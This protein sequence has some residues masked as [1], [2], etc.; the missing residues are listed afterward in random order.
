MPDDRQQ[1]LFGP[2]PARPRREHAAVGPAVAPPELA[3]IASRIPPTVRLGTSSWSF[4]GWA[5]IV[6][7]RD[8]SAS[9]LARDGLAAYARHPLLR[10]VGIDRTYYAPISAEVYRGY[11]LAVPETF[12][13][14]A[15]ACSDCTSPASRDGSANPK[16]LDAA[17]A[18]DAVV[19]PF[20]EGL[21][22][23]AGPLVF[24][25][26]PLGEVAGEP[27]RFAERLERFLAALPRGPMY[28]VEVRDRAV[29]GPGYA[30]ALAETGAAHCLSVHPRM[31][32]VATQ[33]AASGRPRAEG[34][35]VVRW[36][37]HVGLSYDGARV[38]YAP[39]SRLVDEDFA[40]RR[41]LAAAIRARAAAGFESFVVA[42]NKAEGS[43]PL[44]VFA[45]AAA[46]AK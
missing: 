28:A 25:F 22:A 44:T 19:A 17:W 27:E 23:K 41:A 21:G 18:G 34:P 1:F 40:T 7:D 10:T 14:L 4:P 8:A 3:E 6:Y 16:F 29:L 42:N 11:A 30:A 33:V 45:L 13:F 38:R 26:P 46:V 31:P 15:K 9:R 5:G 35:L 39:F 24:Q 37:L 43:A 20:V 12:R 32:D 36:M 2:P